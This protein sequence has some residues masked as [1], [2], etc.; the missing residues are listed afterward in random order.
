[1]S[2]VLLE[3]ILS[4][5]QTGVDR[6]ALDWAIKHG[7]PH[8]GWCPKG[9]RA[10]DGMIP[11]RYCLDETP[12]SH[13]RQR[14]KWNVRDADATLIVTLSR[15]LTG[16]TLFTSAYSKR[17]DKPCLHIAQGD[18]WRSKVREFCDKYQIRILNVAGPRSSQAHGIEQ[19]VH[20]VLD[21]LLP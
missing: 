11:Q 3:K 16:G 13:Y 7:I 17:V 10:E 21:C 19:L 9:R 14:T 15:K 20:Q 18:D 4:G 5:G 6:A 8:G 2:I 1:M 12:Q